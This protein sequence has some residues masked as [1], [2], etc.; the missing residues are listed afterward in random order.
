MRTPLLGIDVSGFQTGIDLAAVPSDFVIVKATGGTTLVSS[1]LSGHMANLEGVGKLRAVYH[2]SRDGSNPGGAEAEADHFLRTVEPYWDG[3][4]LPILN[5]E[6]DNALDGEWARAWLDRVRVELGVEPWVNSNQSAMN[7]PGWAAVA[8]YPAWVSA[9]GADQPT[10]DYKMPDGTPVQEAP[11]P[12]LTHWPDGP[13][14]WQ[15]SRNMLLPSY[16]NRVDANIFYGSR[17]TWLQ[18]C[19]N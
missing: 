6:K 16:P 15:F 11:K 10:S 8:N 18:H 17:D 12:V 7:S 2:M 3:E 4:T 9:Y 5:H 19:P 13:M 1:G 14:A